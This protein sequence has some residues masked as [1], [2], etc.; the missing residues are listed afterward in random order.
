MNKIIVR[1][2]IGYD[3]DLLSLS[4]GLEC[5]EPSLTLQSCKDETDINLIVAKMTQTGI[6]PPQASPEAYGDFTNASDYHTL[7]NRLYDAQ[8]TF[9]ELP[10]NVRERF[11]N[12]P[13]NLFDFLNNESNRQE[14]ISLGLIQAPTIA[15]AAPITSASE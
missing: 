9:M 3:A 2:P 15:S 10:A 13:A 1:Q 11:S 5:P 8:D 12:D 7:L 14:A 6:L 4:T